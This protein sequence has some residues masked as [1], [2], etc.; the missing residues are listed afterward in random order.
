[1]KCYVKTIDKISVC[2]F[3]G[4]NLYSNIANLIVT[5]ETTFGFKIGSLDDLSHSGYELLDRLSRRRQYVKSHVRE[6]TCIMAVERV[7]SY[8][9]SDMEDLQISGLG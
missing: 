4:L 3:N 5:M 1:M 2:L 7:P 6:R 9:D 8:S